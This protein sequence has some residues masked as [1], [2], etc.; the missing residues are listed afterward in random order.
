MKTETQLQKSFNKM[1]ESFEAAKAKR[2]SN[3]ESTLAALDKKIQ[4]CEEAKKRLSTELEGI[5]TKE[6]PLSFETFLQQQEK[7]ANSHSPQS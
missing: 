4:R 6:F 2:I 7:N 3:I 1:K 5:R